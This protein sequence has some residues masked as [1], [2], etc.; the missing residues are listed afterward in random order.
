MGFD[1]VTGEV[2]V[3]DP[4]DILLSMLTKQR[5]NVIFTHN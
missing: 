5:E 3:L 2:C 4:R 1:A